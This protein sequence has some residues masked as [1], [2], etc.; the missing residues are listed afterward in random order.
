MLVTLTL[1]TSIVVKRRSLCRTRR[2]YKAPDT[3]RTSQAP[4]HGLLF[5]A[6]R[7]AFERVPSTIH[8]M[9]SALSVGATNSIIPDDIEEG[10]ARHIW[11]NSTYKT[12]ATR[13]ARSLPRRKG[14]PVVVFGFELV[15]LD[16]V[17]LVPHDIRGL[18]LNQG[19]LASITLRY[20][21]HLRFVEDRFR[22]VP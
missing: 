17:C 21:L 19:C 4:R 2:V 8:Y 11:E 16:R 13:L 1:G 14:K 22:T 5:M 18:L 3:G 10:Q 9:P 12:L 6:Q 15:L 20:R 7:T